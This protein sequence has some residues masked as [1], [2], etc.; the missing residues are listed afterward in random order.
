MGKGDLGGVHFS[1]N[2]L[3]ETTGA[4][5]ILIVFLAWLMV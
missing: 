3:L 2:D 1:V 5:Y 4:R